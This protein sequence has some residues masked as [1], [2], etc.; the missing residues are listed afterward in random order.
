MSQQDTATSQTGESVFATKQPLE[1]EFTPDEM[2]CREADV[3]DLARH[4][5]PVC[6]G[7]SPRDLHVCGPSGVGKSTAVEYILRELAEAE[8]TTEEYEAR[9]VDCSG[10]ESESGL[11]R[12]LVNEFRPPEDEIPATENHT[13][14]TLFDM[15]NQHL[16]SFGETD[17]ADRTPV[18]LVLDGVDNVPEVNR[19]VYHLSRGIGLDSVSVGT[20]WV[21]RSGSLFENLSVH[22]ESSFTPFRLVFDAYDESEIRRILGQRIAV[23]L[24][25]AVVEER[26]GGIG[27]ESEVLASDAFDRV[28]EATAE[29][30]EGDVRDG[31]TL[32]RRAGEAADREGDDEITVQ[33]VESA[34]GTLAE[35]RSGE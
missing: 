10:T 29:R 19:V 21:A 17:G 25:E 5:R 9:H 30:F 32:I 31:L 13:I 4:L 15:L 33:H 1:A 6:E 35:R 23:S 20:V 24:R 12:T 11:V 16:D 7:A 3:R 28:V 8:S 18:V 22:S 2:L 26:A 27:V 34:V 14:S